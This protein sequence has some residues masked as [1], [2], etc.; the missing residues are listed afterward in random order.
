MLLS[1]TCI[2]SMDKDEDDD[3]SYEVLRTAVKEYWNTMREYYKA[4]SFLIINLRFS[5]GMWR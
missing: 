4:V 5:F 1:G 3:N 2:S